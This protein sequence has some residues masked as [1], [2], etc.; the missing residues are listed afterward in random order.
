[1]TDNPVALDILMILQE[2]LRLC[3]I[4]FYPF[5]HAVSYCPMSVQCHKQI[6]CV[7]G[8]IIVA[9]SLLDTLLLLS[10]PSRNSP[11][12]LMLSLS[13]KTSLNF[14]LIS[15]FLGEERDRHVLRCPQHHLTNCQ[16]HSHAES[17]LYAVLNLDLIISL[18]RE[19]HTLPPSHW[20]KRY[21]LETSD[22]FL[23]SA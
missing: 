17:F 13:L 22:T 11:S 18:Q 8:Q 23:K 9:I 3:V 21:Q 15:F 2:C 4:M 1:M 14:V 5:Q 20:A 12:L 16:W 19:Q 10:L 6:I 7:Q